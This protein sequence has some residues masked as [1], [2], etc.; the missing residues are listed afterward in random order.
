MFIQRACRL[1]P[2]FLMFNLKFSLFGKYYC[3]RYYPAHLIWNFLLQTARCNEFYIWKSLTIPSLFTPIIPTISLLF[4]NFYPY[5]SFDGHLKACLHTDTDTFMHICILTADYTVKLVLSGP[6][7]K[8][9]NYRLM[10]VKS[11]AECS[12]GG[13]LQPFRPSLT[14]H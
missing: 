12:N 2:Q 14:Y 10:Q 7:K 3:H 5:F 11:I 9:T 6:S 1:T 4:P 13:I 8:K